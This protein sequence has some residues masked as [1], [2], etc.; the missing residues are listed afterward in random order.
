MNRKFLLSPDAATGGGTTPSTSTT[1]SKKSLIPSDESKLWDVADAV[2]TKWATVPQL[3]CFWKTQATFAKD[4]QDLGLI[5]GKRNASGGN[6][7]P[8]AASLEALDAKVKKGIEKLKLYLQDKY[9]GKVAAQK[10]YPRF[11]IVKQGSNYVLPADRDDRLKSFDLL[12]PAIVTDG[13]GDKEYGTAFWTQLKADYKAALELSK[14]NLQAISGLVGQKK[15]LLA[16]VRKTLKSIL[17]L[18]EGNY[19][20]TYENIAREWGYTRG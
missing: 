10:Q 18:L 12:L 17:R 14:A 6:V 19:P 8:Q 3:V 11:G 4:V 1:A 2:S 15:T 9:D 5:M 7:T 20:D 13:L 16:E